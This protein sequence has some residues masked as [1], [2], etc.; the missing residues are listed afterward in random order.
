MGKNSLLAVLT[1]LVWAFFWPGSDYQNWIRPIAW[2]RNHGAPYLLLLF[3]SIG[4][5]LWVPKDGDASPPSWPRLLFAGT[6]FLSSLAWVAALFIVSI[7]ALFCAR[8]GFHPIPASPASKKW[9][10]ALE[11]GLIG[12]LLLSALFAVFRSPAG[13]NKN[14]SGY[15]A[16][17]AFEEGNQLRALYLTRKWAAEQGEPPAEAMLFL[18]RVVWYMGSFEEAMRIASSLEQTGRTPEI[19]KSAGELIRL[20]KPIMAGNREGE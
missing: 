4:A 7:C 17:A 5:V 2:G 16:Q 6:G 3:F 10:R 20:W 13:E 12:L 8:A 11:G 9:E 15:P 19:R 1:I 14:G 18:S